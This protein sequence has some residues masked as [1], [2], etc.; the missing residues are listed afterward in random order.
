VNPTGNQ[1]AGLSVLSASPWPQLPAGYPQHWNGAASGPERGL[2][3]FSLQRT[4]GS[5]GES[6]QIFT[7][8]ATKGTRKS[9]ENEA[10]GK[11]VVHGSLAGETCPDFD[12]LKFPHLR[13]K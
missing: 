4:Q 9:K 6:N 7:T 13:G 12:S 1:G 2:F 8:K 10:F 5:A 11:G 3:L